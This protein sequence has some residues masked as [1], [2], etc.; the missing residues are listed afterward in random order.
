M[1]DTILT[2][3]RVTILICMAALLYWFIIGFVL[4]IAAKAS[5][6]LLV[7]N[8]LLGTGLYLTLHRT[9][10]ASWLYW[11]LADV[12]V[13]AA[14]SAMLLGIKQL[15]SLAPRYRQTMAV[16]ALFAAALVAIGPD[17]VNFFWMV[18]AF[19]IFAVYL[20]TSL[21]YDLFRANVFVGN[22]KTRL[23]VIAPFVLFAALAVSEISYYVLQGVGAPGTGDPKRYLVSDGPL[24]GYMI[25]CLII[26]IHSVA[27]TL[28][29]LVLQIQEHAERDTL[30]GLFNRRMF[31]KRYD[32]EL[33]RL[34]RHKIGFAVMMIDVDDFKSV[35]DA[36]GHKVG[37]LALQH[38]AHHLSGQLRQVDL[39]ARFGGEEFIVILQGSDLKSASV[40]AERM[41]GDLNLTPFV[42]QDLSRTLTVSIGIASSE[43]CQDRT[44]LQLADR[45]LYEAKG[46]GKNCYRLATTPSHAVLEAGSMRQAL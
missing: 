17:P 25:A 16:L 40:V 9:E 15:F 44:I 20:A 4:N 29:R 45:A 2:L 22:L 30:T 5:R 36:Y 28:T 19:D 11:T 8:L 38:L 21:S 1:S 33:A 39:I 41:L 26:N 18:L 34:E 3:Y 42:Y 10:M 24:W 13:S 6:S 7:A 12:V 35:N 32:E 31:D 43:Q 46:A 14:L 23:V 27:L 37:D